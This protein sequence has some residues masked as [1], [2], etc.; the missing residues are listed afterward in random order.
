MSTFSQSR[1]LKARKKNIMDDREKPSWKLGEFN[2][3]MSEKEARESILK[4]N[5]AY[6]DYKN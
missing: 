6:R 3:K 1:V 5:N 4:F 2:F